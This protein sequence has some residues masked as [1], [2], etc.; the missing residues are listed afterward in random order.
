MS[1]IMVTTIT[2]LEGEHH[3]KSKNQLKYSTN[4]PNNSSHSK[5]KPKE[6]LVNK[7]ASLNLSKTFQAISNSNFRNS[8]CNSKDLNL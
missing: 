6:D 4:L 8:Q 1:S 5:I 7:L 2:V 3:L